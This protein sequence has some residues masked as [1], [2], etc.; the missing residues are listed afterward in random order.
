MKT[1]YVLALQTEVSHNTK[2]TVNKHHKKK[3]KYRNLKKA[4]SAKAIST[5]LSLENDFYIN[6][7]SCL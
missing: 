5:S 7:Q 1:F 2:G 3:N 4:K 6:H